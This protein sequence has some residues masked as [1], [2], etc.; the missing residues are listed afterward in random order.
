MLWSE[1]HS[2]ILLVEK[3]LDGCTVFQSVFLSLT[4]LI[5]RYEGGHTMLWSVFTPHPS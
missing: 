2:Y 3:Y 1:F 4:L 5:E